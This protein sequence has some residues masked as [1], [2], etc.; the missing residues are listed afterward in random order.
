MT[1]HAADGDTAA[2]RL[3]NVL[4]TLRIA[5]HDAKAARQRE[6]GARLRP[7]E[8]AHGPPALER[9]GDQC[10]ARLS[11]C[12]EY[13]ELHPPSSRR[14]SSPSREPRRTPVGTRP[15]VFFLLAGLSA[16][17]RE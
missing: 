5:A 16:L 3:P 9:S 12:A 4:G 2:D 10:P 14:R 1:E 17:V 15:S 8:G 7:H 11:G 6:R 13:G